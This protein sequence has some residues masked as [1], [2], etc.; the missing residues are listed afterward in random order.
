MARNFKNKYGI[1]VYVGRGYIEFVEQGRTYKRKKEKYQVEWDNKS[2]PVEIGT[3]LTFV[4]SRL[5]GG[6]QLIRNVEK[7]FD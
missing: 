7:R 4:E 3:R 2:I 1:I 6:R 5:R